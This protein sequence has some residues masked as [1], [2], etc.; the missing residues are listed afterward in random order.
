VNG[1]TFLV[2]VSSRTPAF[3]L[4]QILD[5]KE[6]KSEM[7]LHGARRWSDHESPFV[8]PSHPWR[9]TDHG[10]APHMLTSLNTLCLH[11]VGV[12]VLGACLVWSAATT[13][14]T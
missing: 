9:V 1:G 5:V 10:T 11:A 12:A 2:P 7:S 13:P 6:Q 3:T 14:R 8:H 4:L